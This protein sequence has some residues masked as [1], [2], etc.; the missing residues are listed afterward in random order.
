MNIVRLDARHWTAPAD[1]YTALLRKLGA[2]DWH[3]D[4]VPALID[5]MIA[6]DINEV[7]RPLRVVV[8]GLDQAGE[9]AFDEMA[10]VFSA[11]ARYGAVARIT[12][13]QASLEIAEDV[14][15]FLAGR[16]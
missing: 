4:C 10:R 2:P 11:L 14:S 6:G 9:A 1:F 16:A 13:D 3:G 7:E 15:P 12:S 8:T 5:S